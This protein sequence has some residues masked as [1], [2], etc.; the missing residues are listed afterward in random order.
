ML[1]I[2]VVESCDTVGTLKLPATP[3]TVFPLSKFA[4]VKSDTADELKETVPHVV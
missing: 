4:D 2:F 3:N 1:K